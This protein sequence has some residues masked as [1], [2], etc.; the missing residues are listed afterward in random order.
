MKGEEVLGEDAKKSVKKSSAVKEA[1]AGTGKQ[2]A[3][4]AAAQ[5]AVKAVG[6]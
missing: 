1:E 2:A 5:P 3:T 6:K 4:A